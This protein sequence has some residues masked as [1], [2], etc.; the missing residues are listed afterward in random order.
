M[1]KTAL[2]VFAVAILLILLLVVLSA[3]GLHLYLK[4]DR[5]GDLVL[6]TVNSLIPGRIQAEDVSV[7]LLGQSIGL[8]GA[9]LL[10]PD[11]GTILSSEEVRIELD[12]LPLLRNRLVFTVISLKGPEVRLVMPGDGSELNL[13]QAFVEE[14]PGSPPSAKEE[15]HEEFVVIIEELAVESGFIQYAD[16]AADIAV[17]LEDV[18]AESSLNLARLSG[19]IEGTI[20]RVFVQTGG[21]PFELTGVRIDSAY[22]D[23][24]LDPLLLEASYGDFRASISGTATDLTGKPA[25]DAAVEYDGEVSGLASLLDPGR[26]YTGR[27]SG[28]AAVRGSL[29]NPEASATLRY[30]GGSIA[31]I[32]VDGLMLEVALKDRVLQIKDSIL[33]IASGKA[34][35]GGTINLAQA[36]PRGFIES[37]PDL[38]AV[39]YKISS[40]VAGIDMTRFFPGRE[41][42]PD[43]VSGRI[44]IAGRGIIPPNITARSDYVLHVKGALPDS[45]V[46]VG[47][48][49]IE[50]QAGLDYPVLTYTAAGDIAGNIDA[51]IR[52]RLDLAKESIRTA[53]NL[54]IRQVENIASALD[55]QARGSL[56]A[57]AEISGTL[58]SPVAAGTLK[59][60]NLQWQDYRIGTVSAD[61][62]L[63]ENGM[64]NLT[65]LTMNQAGPALVVRGGVKVFREGLTPDPDLPVTLDIRLKSAGI[66]RLI[67]QEGMRGI[68]HG[69]VHVEGNLNTPSVAV[70]L[71]GED[72]TVQDINLGNIR[73]QGSLAAEGMQTRP[74]PPAERLPTKN[75]RY[76]PLLR[77]EISGENR[78]LQELTDLAQGT[79]QYTAMIRGSL[80]NPRGTFEVSGADIV[81]ADQPMEDVK[82]AGE[83]LGFQV[84]VR[85][86]TAVIRGEQIITGSGM[87]D[88]GRDNEYDFSLYTNGITLGALAAFQG[89]QV[90]GGRLVFDISGKGTLENPQLD[91]TVRIAG[92]V[93][94]G[95]VLS[96]IA[97]DLHLAR[98]EVDIT[99]Q[100]DFAF[101]GTY[102]LE[103]ETID[104]EA[105]FEETELAPYFAIAGRPELRGILSGS[106]EITGN[107]SDRENLAVSLHIAGIRIGFRERELMRA[108]DLVIRYGEGSLIVPESRIDLLEKGSMMIRADAA[109]QGQLDIT[110]RGMIPLD[111]AA[112]I[113]PD[114]ADL[115][116]TARF[117]MEASGPILSPRIE[118]EVFIEGARYPI[119]YNG[120]LLHDMRGHIRISGDG[121]LIDSLA[122]RLDQGYFEASGR[123]GL[124]NLAPGRINL[125]VQARSLPVIIPETMD[126]VLEGQATLTGMPDKSLLQ[127]D[128]TILD[129]LYYREHQLNI[130]AEVGQRILGGG[131]QTAIAPEPV[132]LPYLRNADLDV[133]VIRRGS[134]LIENN[135]AEISIAPDL[136]VGGTL[137]TPIITGRVAVIEGIVTYQR[138][139]FDVT[140]GVLEFA[141]PYRTRAVVDLEAQGQVRDW[142]IYLSVSGPLDNLNIGLESDPA[143]EDAA[144]LSLLAT[145]RTPDELMGTG[146]LAPRSPSSMLAELL[147]STYGEELR[148]T[149]GLDILELETVS[150]EPGADAGD[151]R[152]TVGEELTRRLT[153]KYSLETTSGEM[154]RTAIAEYKFFENLLINGFQDNKGAFGADLQFRLEFR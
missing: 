25:V 65:D 111:V 47:E 124:E 103:K 60:K 56:S 73:I 150:P 89:S 101:K 66:D 100:N 105:Y 131:R 104:L 106:A 52:G 44:E 55:I 67:V 135:L 137:N 46:P 85:S 48:I 2:R 117:D 76:D 115:T 40:T 112:L 62:R 31:G 10:G 53:V 147:A 86:L 96:D 142:M 133:S 26:S 127:A 57:R 49:D 120:Q 91:G 82:A 51:D 138:R 125:Q 13:I 20:A 33:N 79:L 4:T 87:I 98:G 134:V 145:G 22:E 149:T 116:G 107:V 58:G 119:P 24:G 27:V 121:V 29:D 61:L 152:I 34:I 15:N 5:G 59:G 74:L 114:L 9:V 128:V 130:V 14:A 72:V 81:L 88:P 148:E 143:L 136:Q 50:G 54:D 7:S 123:V 93:V 97:I 3:A 42:Y 64:L 39:S 154:T 1:M 146:A 19:R 63:D 71:A 113:D 141:D 92:P 78:N 18:N 109:P 68:L 70:D 38:D 17:R 144:I 32:S 122:G 30:E 110:A 6:G 11:N 41:A 108:G 140:R 83:I 16:Q 118:G 69:I 151:I 132:D 43:S 95:Q 35:A 12:L 37:D 21:S 23:G 153:V 94:Q 129:A 126:L 80:E 28:R 8:T 75:D 90:T 102:N 84:F 36:F 139:T 77:L 99:G 45:P